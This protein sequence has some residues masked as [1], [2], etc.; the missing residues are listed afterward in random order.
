MERRIKCLAVAAILA[1]A[2]CVDGTTDPE[3]PANR[4][5]ATTGTIPAQTVH[6][7]DMVTVDLSGYFSDPD[8]DALTYSAQ[9]S[10]GGVATVSLSGAIAVVS[11]VTQGD[12]TIAATATDPDGLSAQQSF[13]VNVPNRAPQVVGNISDLELLAGDTAE[14]DVSDYFTDPDGDALTYTVTTSD[15]GVATTTVDGE[16]VTVVA[17]SDGSASLTVSAND[18]GGLSAD[19]GFF[20]N[21]EP[22]GDPRIQFVTVSAAVPEGG[23]LVVEVEARPVPQSTLDVGYSIGRD[24]APTADANG[25][26][27]DGGSG[28]DLRFEAG[29]SRVA[30]EITIQDDDDIEPT[31][32]H[33]TV[34]LDTP[35]EGA[36]YVLGSSITA[37]VTI[38]E[39]VCDR[40]PRVRDALTALSGVD[41][42][43]EIDR[44]HLAAIDTLDLR[45]LERGGA[46]MGTW[47][48]S[49]TGPISGGCHVAT[50]PGSS[51]APLFPSRESSMCV[52][53]AF[54]PA[55][56]PAATH[57]NAA[58]SNKPIDEL[59]VGD[60]L[61]LDELEYLWLAGNRLTELP[62]GVFSGLGEL[63]QLHLAYNR[64]REL[65]ENLLSGLSRLEDF[66]INDNEL[67]RLPPD[68][69]T[70]LTQLREVWMSANELVELPPGLVSDAGYL[71]EL[72]FWGNR[73]RA[74]PP[75]AFSGLVYLK[76]LS[77]GS[78]SLTEMD[79]T[80]FSDLSDL[81]RLG[82]EDNRLAELPVGLF[83]N[84]GNLEGLWIRQN[85]LEQLQ[86]GL[87]DELTNLKLLAADSNRI[88]NLRDGTFSNLS[89]LDHL[90]LQNNR[91]SEIRAGMFTGLG[92]LERLSVGGNRFATLEPGAFASLANLEHLWLARG[93]ITEVRPGAFNGL[94]RLITLGLWENQLSV[95]PDGVFAGLPLLEELWVYE[96]QIEEISAEVFAGLPLL[97]TLVM[98]NNRL[99]ELPPNV[100]ASL[101]NL[102][103]LYLSGN[104]IARMPEGA[105]SNLATLDTL[106][107][108]H[109]NLSELPDGF[110]EGLFDLDLLIAHSNPGAPFS[111]A[112]QLERRD[113]TD[114]A[115]P[116]PARV[117]LS[118]AKGAPLSVKIPLSVDGGTLSADTAVIMQ[119]H[120]TSAEF[121]VTMSSGSQ[122]GTQVIAGPAPPVHDRITGVELVAADTLVLFA[123]SGG[124]RS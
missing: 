20:A 61:E 1:V 50:R 67:T 54:E 83:R 73:L 33:F 8:G 117:V 103:G 111:L 124:P 23:R 100:F 89:E 15:A 18:P 65:P 27:H 79:G 95:L 97:E 44:S 26:D 91:L 38:Q 85:R 92:G 69:F 78:N 71:R 19:Q 119:G 116:G 56:L 104:L 81:E 84:L 39:G 112:V 11:G 88:E 123:T 108:N 105:L 41:M 80:A 31:R 37:F 55:P 120:T 21:V 12:A 7:G 114:L 75:D 121:T 51:R 2:A 122:S 36:G 35:E 118:L 66:F 113:A 14:I 109:N 60:F 115:A 94:S 49:A 4:P 16:T 68:L 45:G 76:V 70:G 13:S 5:P 9:T 58:G 72:H 62:G 24:D 29:E 40:T 48:R 59:R 30:L 63:R 34:A 22:D 107:L 99:T 52:T 77:L 25:L 86:D 3:P 42:C 74:L 98:W 57:G 10:N 17:V 64:I 106:T 46:A 101:G 28:G 32:E 53:P 87:L 82:L 110:F 102:D 93:E 96:N 43:H 47:A 90:L 6:V